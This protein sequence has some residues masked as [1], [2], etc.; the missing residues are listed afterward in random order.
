MVDV[1]RRFSPSTVAVA[2]LATPGMGILFSALALGE[3]VGGSL[4]LGL[5]LIGAGIRC[6]TLPVKVARGGR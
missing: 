4:L 6:A 1:G 2:L 5:A 3:P